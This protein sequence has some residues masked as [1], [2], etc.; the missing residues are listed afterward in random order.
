[1]TGRLPPSA[2]VAKARE[3]AK[4]HAPAA[5]RNA[6]AISALLAE[7]APKSGTALELASGTGQHVIQFAAACPGLH[8]HPTEVDTARIA[9]INAYAAD[10]AHD[11]NAPATK[12]NAA[13]AGW[14]H[15][16]NHALV[17]LINLL[18]LVS[19]DATDVILREAALALVHDGVFVLY[20]PFRRAGRLTSEG[21]VRFDAELRAADPAIGYKDDGWI[22]ARLKSA[23]LSVEVRE[24]AANNLAFIARKTA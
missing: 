10:A 1:M 11:T 19:D 17:V 16:K 2:S 4:L 9:S 20:G 15:G 5:G 3:G 8:W 6:D 21:D 7:V 14:S 24:M 12:L 18:H 23:G 22:S 13:Y